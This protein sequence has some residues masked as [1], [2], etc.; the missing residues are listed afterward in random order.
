[1][2]N[3]INGSSA[4]LKKS[5]PIVLIKTPGDCNGMESEE[6]KRIFCTIL[7]TQK[8][9]TEKARNSGMQTISDAQ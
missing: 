5:D 6:M 8:E 7:G 2:E 4:I 1:M 3:N 9:M